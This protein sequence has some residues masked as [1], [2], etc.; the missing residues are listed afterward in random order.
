MEWTKVVLVWIIVRVVIVNCNNR[1]TSK[2]L[3]TSD[4]LTDDETKPIAES[5]DAKKENSSNY[6]KEKLAYHEKKT[7][8]ELK[9]IFEDRL[10]MELFALVQRCGEIREYITM[11]FEQE[12]TPERLATY[13]PEMY[14]GV[15]KKCERAI[16]SARSRCLNLDEINQ[17]SEL[18]A[19]M[20]P[21]VQELRKEQIECLIKKNAQSVIQA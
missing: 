7:V 9:G 2:T 11:M 3:D 1:A 16:I 12:M 18:R 6:W 19:T 20:S 8:A 5:L 21:Y 14:I 10:D 15:M 4:N 13:T 17:L